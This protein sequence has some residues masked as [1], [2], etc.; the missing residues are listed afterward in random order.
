MMITPPMTVFLPDEAATLSLGQQLA[1]SLAAG[2]VVYLRG[3]LGAGKTTLVRG[4]LQALGHRGAVKSPTY[5]LCEPYHLADRTVF[6]LD[7]Y[8]LRAAAEW[9][10]LGIDE[11]RQTGDV[12]VIEWPEQAEGALPP[13]TLD[14][15][16]SWEAPAGRTAVIAAGSDV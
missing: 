7:L 10:Q 15:T 13:A 9:G 3:D 16:L 4:F 6:H 12:V 2:G 14:V 5:T 8:R 11:Q 1:A